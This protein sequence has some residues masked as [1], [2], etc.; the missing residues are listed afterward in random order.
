MDETFL[1]SILPDD[2]TPISLSAAKARLSDKFR[3]EVSEIDIDNLIWRLGRDVT[4]DAEKLELC[5]ALNTQL[6]TEIKIERDLEGWFERYLQREADDQFFKY[7]P[8]SLSLLIQNT[9]RTGPNTGDFTKPDVCM[10]AISRYHYTPSARLDLFCFELKLQSGT[11]LGS[12]GQ[13]KA[14]T[15]YGHYSYLAIYLPP[16]SKYLEN[17]RTVCDEAQSQGIGII[18]ISDPFFDNGYEVLIL[19]S[20]HNPDPAKT[21]K[22]IEDRFSR[23][24]RLALRKWVR[25]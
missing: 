25:S 1:L 20:R 9:A 23:A 19:A 12:V 21:D 15:A 10:T 3:C 2:G 4:L 14:Y 7:K 8:S 13:A 22:F 24:N 16:K 17:L 6:S 11:H 5:R 18:R